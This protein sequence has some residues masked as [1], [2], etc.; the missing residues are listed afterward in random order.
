MIKI[1]HLSY[2]DNYGGASIA[3]KRINE[4]LLLIDNIDSKIAVVT[5][6]DN[7]NVICLSTTLFD[8]IWLYIRTRL[9]YKLVVFLQ[10]SNNKSGRSINFFPSTVYNRL[11]ELEFD[12]LHLHW[13]GNETISLEDL[14]KI[15]KPIVWTFH[16]K[17]ALLGAEHTEIKDSIRFIEGYSRTNKPL[18]T[19]GIDIDRWTWNRKRRALNNISIQP[20]VVSSWL[21]NETTK[22]FLWKKSNPI[23]IHN[24]IKV[25][26]WEIKDKK[27]CRDFFNIPF[28]HNVIVFGAVNAF[29]DTLKGYSKLEEAVFIHSKRLANQKFTLLVFGDPDVKDINLSTNINLKSIGQIRDNTVLNRIYCCG[30]LVAVP[31]Y[32][33]T[34]GQV[35]VEAISC[36]IPVIAFKT[37]GLLDIVIENL[38]GVL[39]KPFDVD[40]MADKIQFALE[41]KWDSKA[42]RND[43]DERFGY[44]Q[45]AKKYGL[46]YKKIIYKK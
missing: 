24:P 41:A 17:W 38:N 40:D 28:D 33:E 13:I 5:S 39:C 44:V 25:E 7:P 35:A 10:K 1:L 11:S 16:D 14:A 27:S 8:K 23:I 36:G 2:S 45:I 42:M 32:V 20:V 15:K 19:V 9:A 43:I 30:D 31:S 22:S 46:L 4:S 3:M 21:A 37:S 6:S 29:S 34:F 26:S 12:I 18:T